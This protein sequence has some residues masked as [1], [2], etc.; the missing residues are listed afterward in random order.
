MPHTRRSLRDDLARL[1][2]KPGDVVMVHASCRAV[3]A[4]YG[5]PDEIHQ[6]VVDAVSPGGTM[7]MLLGCPDGYDDVGRGHLTDEEEA[8]ILEHMPAFDKNATRA[9]RDVGTLAEFFRSWPGTECSDCPAVRIGARGARASWLVSEH[10]L[11][12]PFGHGTPFEKLVTSRGKVLLLG[13]DRDEVTL[14]HY[15]EHTT[16]FPGKIVARYKS[17][18]LRDG[19]RVWVDCEEIDSS[20]EGCHANWPDRF[21]ALIVDDFIAT[22]RGRSQSREGRI[23]N[24]ASFLLDADALVRHAAPI[25]ARTAMGNPYFSESETRRLS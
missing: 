18:V 4:V 7:M 9:T 6:A 22:H 5:G 25:M 2:L 13:S 8:E 16:E 3:G 21:F 1:G 10:P 11:K 14:M 24:A 12:M 23:G 17:P 20:S 19:H 15:A